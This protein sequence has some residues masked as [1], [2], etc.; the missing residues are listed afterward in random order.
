MSVAHLSIRVRAMSAREPGGC[1]S[2]TCDEVLARIHEFLDGELAPEAESHVRQHLTACPACLPKF[3]HE[4]AFL[5]FLRRHARMEEAPA[6]LR[7]R[8]LLALLS[9]RRSPES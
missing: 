9:G 5:G 3:E 4:S 8:I 7:R 1:P 6:S 2:W